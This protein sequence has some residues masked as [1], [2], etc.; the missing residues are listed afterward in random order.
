ML[1]IAVIILTR[2]LVCYRNDSIFFL[3]LL[4]I[5]TRSPPSPHG[6]HYNPMQYLQQ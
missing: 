6:T 3:G 5:I 2:K 1:V 4:A